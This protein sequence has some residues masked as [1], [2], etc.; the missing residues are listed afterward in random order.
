MKKIGMIV[1]VEIDAVLSRYGM[2]AEEE[3]FGSYRMSRYD[4]ENYTLYV[5]HSGAGEIA[6]AACTQLLISVYHVDFILNFGVVGGLT[7]EMEKCRSCIIEKV[8]HYDFD[9]SEI[10]GTRVGQYLE[11]PD[12]YIPVS[13]EL[14]DRA[15]Q[16]A[17]E[18]KP[19][20]CASG[21]KFVADP[22][23]KKALHR[24]Y[25]ADICEMEAAA[26]SLTCYRNHVPCLLIKTVSDGI[27]GGAQE[28]QKE[29]QR[30]SGI[31]LEIADR[32]IR[33]A[34]R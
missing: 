19:V 26:V 5:M 14:F 22:E 1:A 29:L 28:F 25:G 17:P 9:C 10:D 24:K 7:E 32:V 12:E 34:A 18:L 13:K 2:P 15:R 6:A 20:V 21:D 30:T 4:T 27:R 11:L 3:S 31:C 16:I 33:E 23:V 8:V